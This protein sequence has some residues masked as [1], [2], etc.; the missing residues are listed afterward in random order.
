MSSIYKLAAVE[1]A[2]L[3]TRNWLNLLDFSDLEILEFSSD[4]KVSSIPSYLNAE[5][6]RPKRTRVS[7]YPPP[8][9]GLGLDAGFYAFLLRKTT[10][11]LKLGQGLNPLVPSIPKNGTP[12]LT[13]HRGIGARGT[14]R[15]QR[16]GPD[17]A[18]HLPEAL[19]PR[20]RKSMH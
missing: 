17:Q 18:L 19:V 12:T 2:I 4:L 10:C 14:F 9:Y 16:S 15:P 8:H 11:G 7:H 13:L 5:T 3:G 20:S 1:H 6:S